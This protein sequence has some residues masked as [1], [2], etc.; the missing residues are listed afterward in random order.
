MADRDSVIHVVYVN[1]ILDKQHYT[2]YNETGFGNNS[3][4]D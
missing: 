2:R 4:C 3:N 1:F